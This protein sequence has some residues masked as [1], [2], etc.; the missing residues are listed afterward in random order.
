M[1]SKRRKMN[2]L[3]GPNQA[4][5]SHENEDEDNLGLLLPIDSS[6]SRFELPA[7]DGHNSSTSGHA[8][9]MLKLL[10]SQRV[11][12]SLCD[13]QIHLNGRTFYC[14]KC[15]LIA[16][17]DFFRAMLTS[18]SM[19]ESRENY[20]ELKGFASCDGVTL[21]LDFIYTG[22]LH[23]SFDNVLSILD[24]ASHLQIEQ[25]LNLCADFLA[26]NI[27]Y[28]NC[29]YILKIADIYALKDV[30]NLTQI[31]LAENIVDIYEQA[32]E[33]F[34]QLSYEQ[35]K[36]L[37]NNQVVFLASVTE[38]DLFLMISKWIESPESSMFAS[39][40]LSIASFDD[41][42]PQSGAGSQSRLRFAPDLIKHVR[43]MCMSAE[44]LCDHVET[45]KFMRSIPEC[46][47]Y[48]MSAYKWHAL[49]RRQP[50]VDSEQSRLRN[51]EM[52]VAVGE[53][54]IYVLNELKKKW[55][56]VSNAPLEDNYPYPFSIITINNYL[57]VLGT[58]RSSSEEYK[59]CYRFSPRTLE[60]TQLAPF[61]HDRSRFGLAFIDNHIYVFGGFEG[62]KRSNRIFLNNI[63]R[64]SIEKDAWEE[65]SADGPIMSCM[66]SCTL[67]GQIYFGGGKN[68]NW[69]KV[70]DFYT[71][72][73]KTKCISK[74]AN[75]LTA[76][77]THQIAVINDLI[78]VLGGFD[79]AGN[80]ILSIEAYDV[81]KDQWF[82][83]TAIPGDI[84]KTWPQSLGIFTDRFY[85]SVFTTPNTFK[86]MQKGFF[87]DTNTNVWSEAPVI[88]ERAR[89]CPTAC[90][91]FPT[92]IYNFNNQ[93]DAHDTTLNRQK[94]NE[95]NIREDSFSIVFSNHFNR[96]L[97]RTIITDDEVIN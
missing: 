4:R 52:L 67:N 2:E 62:F 57:Y 43:F 23:I 95:Q 54:N 13:Y 7:I 35:L 3:G 33:Q 5:A 29:V 42:D 87:Y 51:Q 58:R 48:L 47:S 8:S 11:E 31:F 75:L 32:A 36:N 9:H 74:K 77:T 78:Y 46:Y 14:H 19:K 70:S 72:N 73:V 53:T 17:S 83:V 79:D 6:F 55:D 12:P 63:D 40:H 82:T 60:W 71:I 96:C 27:S 69:S 38:L 76:R 68:I 80:G 25:V 91:A 1:T 21:I 89:Y 41:G 37:L 86:I 93:I 30:F 61:L 34:V 65:F 22:Y 10:N 24:T 59:A 39:A 28:F 84:S 18:S 90:L 64:Y 66:A 45:V 81:N 97:N 15:V 20:V 94:S 44:E 56:I 50:L 16:V 85:I 88:N 92:K 49:P 26:Q